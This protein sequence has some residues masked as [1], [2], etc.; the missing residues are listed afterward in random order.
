MRRLPAGL[1]LPRGF[2]GRWNHEYPK[3]GHVHGYQIDGTNCPTVT[4]ILQMIAKPPLLY[5]YGQQ[6]ALEAYD[7]SEHLLMERDSA[8]R[9]LANAGNRKKDE[10]AR[11]GSAI[12]RYAD[13]LATTG[14]MPLVHPDAVP[15]V[16]SL[17]AWV[18]DHP[19]LVALS[20]FVVGHRTL[21]HFYMGTADQVM[22]I[23]GELLL[24]DLKTGKG[25]WPEHRLQLAAYRYADFMLSDGIETAIPTVDGCAIL[26]VRP[27]GTEL[28]RVKAEHE[29][30]E[31][32]LACLD[33]WRWYDQ[34]KE[35]AE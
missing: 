2:T 34:H 8:I 33:L 27:E 15:F 10:A 31:A 21:G 28:I 19:H 9:W 23:D 22:D 32:F 4:E 13:E 16:A 14:T 12:H 3:L 29:E 1:V 5:W 17:A 11:L 20:E 6:A 30:F 18:A 35:D 24:V 7:G 26:H 25:I